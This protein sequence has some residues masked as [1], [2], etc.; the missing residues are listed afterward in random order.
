[1]DEQRATLAEE[2]EEFIRDFN[3][4]GEWMFQHSCLLEL[5]TEMKPLSEEEKTEETRI[6]GCQ[7]KLWVLPEYKDGL[8]CVR[9]DSDALI[10][11][12]MIA[13]IV[14]LFDE[15]TPEEVCNAKIDFI[16]RTSLKE[17]IS[18]DRFNGMN[19][20]IRLIQDFAASCME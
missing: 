19:K 13:V 8:I 6:K 10:V 7:A 3:E 4:I 20:V 15:R 16:E 12:G 18:T 17:Q 5:T 1:M 14:A 11:K 2:Q 9:A